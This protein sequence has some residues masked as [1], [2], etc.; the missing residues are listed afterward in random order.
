MFDNIFNKQKDYFKRK[1]QG[2]QYSIWDL[3]FKRFKAKEL[4]EGVR[5]AY[6]DSKQKLQGIEF[7]RKTAEENK[8][9]PKEEL[10]GLDDKIVLLKRDIERYEA[11][12]RSIDLQIDGSKQTNEYPEGYEG[13]EQNLDGLR[14]LLGMVDDYLKRL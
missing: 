9:L 14:E 7:T 3:E 6:D 12:M 1:R 4:R 2:I 13:L 5:Q 11:Q 8:M 10:A